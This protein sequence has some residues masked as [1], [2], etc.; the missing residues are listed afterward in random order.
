MLTYVVL[1]P[2]L[3]Y[4]FAVLDFE[5]GTLLVFVAIIIN[6][7]G[8]GLAEPVGIRFGKHKYK[9]RAL[10]TNRTYTRSYEGS[11]CVWLSAY[12]GVLIAIS[13]FT[14]TQ[15]IIAL[16]VIPPFS[17][18]A[19]AFSPHTVDA[20]ALFLVVLGTIAIIIQI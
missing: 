18:L 14:T 20:P 7:I 4:Y 12:L 6:G 5:E 3:Y 9:T 10:C 1:V 16:I 17:T 11:A 2:F 8:D 19:E 15:F 13:A